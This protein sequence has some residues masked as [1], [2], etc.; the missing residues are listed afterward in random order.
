MVIQA[1]RVAQAIGP[2][3]ETGGLG[4]YRDDATGIQFAVALIVV[5]LDVPKVEPIQGSLRTNCVWMAVPISC[6]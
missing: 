5:A 6:M 1:M 4:A 2:R 3:S